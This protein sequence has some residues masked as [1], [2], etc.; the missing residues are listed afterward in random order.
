M[1][2]LRVNGDRLWD[3]I[4]QTAGFGLTSAGGVTRL[5]LSEEDKQARDWFVAACRDIGCDVWFDEVGNIFARR[6]G[7]DN[8]LD[9]VAMGSHLDTQP[10]GGRFDGI[11]GVLAGL[12]VLHTLEEN[13]YRTRAPLELIDWTNEEGSRFAPTMIASGAFAGVYTT[14]QAWASTDSE[15]TTFLEALEWIGYRGERK[16]GDHLLAGYFE[17]HIEQ[18]PVLYEEGT[19]IGVVT[20]AQ[21]QQWYDITAIGRQG[22]AGTTPM[23]LRRDPMLACARMTDGAVG[24]A[25]RHAPLGVATIG[26]VD[27]SPNSRNVIPGSVFFTIDLR[28]PDAAEL[29]RMHRELVELA[30][31][32]GSETK[33]DVVLKRVLD[34]PP[35][36]FDG[37]C[38]A[39]VRDVAEQLGYSHRDIVSGPGHDALNIAKVAP[40]VMV[41]VPCEKGISHNEAENARKDDVT[42]GANVLLHAVL[43]YDRGLP[44][45][46]HA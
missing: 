18:G 31:R 29:R 7:Q 24:I 41:F 8:S 6:A 14:E 35:M 27:V 39:T 12:E 3:T 23:P 17:L 36:T 43:Q 28:H 20:G 15:G 25:L 1:Q 13:G 16:A 9:P 11:A 40:A 26:H 2:T 30:E 33:T 38:I 34:M 10:A 46:L 19:T 42:A 21:G 5:T 22:H 37:R 44:D 45:V 4:V 32:V